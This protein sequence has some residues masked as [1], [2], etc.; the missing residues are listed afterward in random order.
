[1]LIEHPPAGARTRVL[2]LILVA[3]ALGAA[4]LVFIEQ[5]SPLLQ[6]WVVSDPEGGLHRLAAVLVALAAVANLPLL[7]GAIYFWRLGSQTLAA[8]R[9]PPAGVTVLRATPVLTGDAARR[10]GRAARLCAI[11]LI[12]C[13]IGLVV[14]LLGL[15]LLVNGELS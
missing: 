9:F 10:R 6:E 11:G 12:A 3:T 2:I 4:V 13:S 14:V 15:A 1:M 8:G 7:L 5:W